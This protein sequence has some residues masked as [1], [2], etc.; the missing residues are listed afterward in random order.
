M[1]LDTLTLTEEWEEKEARRG[2]FQTG[3]RGEKG[4]MTRVV[5]FLNFISFLGHKD[6]ILN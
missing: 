5:L 3:R 6:L 4:R 2:S 1:G